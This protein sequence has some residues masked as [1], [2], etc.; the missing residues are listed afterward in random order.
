M[1]STFTLA[2]CSLHAVLYHLIDSV[3]LFL[4][5]QIAFDGVRK[6]LL[7]GD[8]F[9][10]VTSLTFFCTSPSWFVDDCDCFLATH[11]ARSDYVSNILFA[12][13]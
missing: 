9:W 5:A 11:T 13:A 6:R 7:V 8:S 10:K 4:P 3:P 2:S 1:K 12:V